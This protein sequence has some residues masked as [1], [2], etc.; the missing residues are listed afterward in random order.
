MTTPRP[1]DVDDLRDRAVATLQALVRIRTVSH[2]DPAQRDEAPF[3]AFA[4]E[5]RRRLPLL[6]QHLELTTL[7]GHA[8][9]FRWRGRSSDRPV[10]L[11]AHVDVVPVAEDAP[12]QHPAWDATV[13]DGHVWGRG[14]LDDKGPLVCVV[15]AVERLLARGF[16]PAQ[17]VWLSF[18]TTEEVSGETAGLAVDELERRGVEPWFVVDEGGAVAHDAF[19]GIAPPLGVV[20]V[21]EKGT[22]TLEL[23]VDGRGGHASTP[24]RM[25]AVARL[26]RAVVR[27]D[28][29]PLPASVPAPTI[30]LF[31]R[32]APHAPPPLRPLLANAARL[33]PVVAR[34]L[35]A[36]GPETAAMARTTVAV[37]TLS[38]SPAH[39]VLAST[40][41]A[42]VN[43]RVMLGDTVAGVVEHLRRAI[44]D[45]QVQ[46]SVVD[47]G[48][49][50]PLSPVDDDAFRLLERTIGAQFPEAVVTPYVMMA[51]T[52]SRFFT[53][54]CPRV[55]RWS[56][57]RMTKAQRQSIHSYDEH[58]GVDD[59]A[60]GVLWYERLI[61]ALT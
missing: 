51:A 33:R 40:A 41:R 44:G 38:G 26:A 2:A 12:W 4:D 9:L 28:R 39:N 18:G 45:D 37:T 15:E 20:G 22:T 58:V 17:D 8:L 57:L 60:D 49:A 7:P 36:A 21:T 48:E 61:E 1:D 3:V 13:V 43:V 59:L 52:D 23:R 42:G 29:S 14:T 32:I 47:P 56:P 19:P 25:D 16:V 54:I 6:H 31:R 55:Y 24:S 27:L 50:S 35:V 30:E 11:M 34:A 53:R 10:V 46:V 5:L